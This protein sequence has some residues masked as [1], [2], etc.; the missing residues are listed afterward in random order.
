M[1]WTLIYCSKRREIICLVNTESLQRKRIITDN[2]ILIQGVPHNLIIQEV[3]NP[4]DKTIQVK[5]NEIIILHTDQQNPYKL[6]KNWIQEKTTKQINQTLEKYSNQYHVKPEIIR[7]VDTK[8]WG[9]CN[10]D[11]LII[12]NWQLSTLPHELVEFIVM[13]E[14]IH[15]THFNHQKTFHHKLESII[16]NHRQMEEELKQYVAIP[17]GFEKTMG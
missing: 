3:K 8:R 7:V 13:H 11:G 12:Y 1:T 14:V 4:P 15:L 2:Q 5:P 10:K 17:L 9:Y 16:P 6:L